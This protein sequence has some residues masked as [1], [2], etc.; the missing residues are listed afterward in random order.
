MILY[1]IPDIRLFWTSDERFL[2]QFQEGKV[3]TFTPYSK[4]PG[5]ARDVSFWTPDSALEKEKKKGR[6]EREEG[7]KRFHANDF[8]DL[9]REVAGDLVEEVTVV[10]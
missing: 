8:C 4:Y 1:S 7:V 10:C 9:V 3:T 5:I 2:S 6:E